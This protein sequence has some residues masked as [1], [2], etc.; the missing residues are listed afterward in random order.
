MEY[1]LISCEVF[2]TS[3]DILFEQLHCS[4]KTEI[5]GSFIK[6]WQSCLV[7]RLILI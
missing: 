1:S 7:F 3:V 4:I 2:F 6:P 5:L